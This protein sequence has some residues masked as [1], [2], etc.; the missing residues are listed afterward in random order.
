M[1][2]CKIISHVVAKLARRTRCYKDKKERQ[3][4]SDKVGF[5]E[6][7]LSKQNLERFSRVLPSTEGQRGQCRQ[8]EQHKQ[9]F[10]RS[11]QE[12]ASNK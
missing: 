4:N 3:I 8:R 10:T 5:T 6:K 2:L 9:M 12:M 1:N 7:V 11:A